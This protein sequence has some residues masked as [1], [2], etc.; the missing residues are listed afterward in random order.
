MGNYRRQTVSRLMPDHWHDVAYWGLLLVACA[1]FYWM[2]VL[3]PY[4]EDDMGFT[5][6]DGEH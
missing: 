3:T 1:V 6:I 2:N 5:L 4:K